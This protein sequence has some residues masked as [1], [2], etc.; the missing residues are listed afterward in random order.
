MSA[1]LKRLCLISLLVCLGSAANAQHLRV[2]TENWPPYNFFNQN[3]QIVGSSTEVVRAVLE[4]AG[5]S[6]SIEVYPWARSYSIAQNNSNVLIYTIL[7]T[8][9][10]E[11]LLK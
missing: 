3:D 8:P 9:F 11:N 2:V 6:Y 10:R 7:R 1:G 5:F 4:K